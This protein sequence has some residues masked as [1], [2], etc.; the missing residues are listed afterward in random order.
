MFF[1]ACVFNTP[2]SDV[3]VL[4]FWVQE[5]VGLLNEHGATIAKL[6]MKPMS[7]E[8]FTEKMGLGEN[9]M[10]P[11]DDLSSSVALPE[12]T[13]AGGDDTVEDT[14]EGDDDDAD[15]MTINPSPPAPEKEQGSTSA[16]VSEVLIPFLQNNSTWLDSFK[17]IPFSFHPL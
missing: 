9:F 6:G 16:P 14:V 11:T 4:H 15:G 7:A 8:A 3:E 5:M 13:E 1:L 10:K 2:V 12:D 17:L